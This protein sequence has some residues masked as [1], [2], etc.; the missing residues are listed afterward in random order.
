MNWLLD[1]SNLFI[2]SESLSV[3]N[4]MFDVRVIDV[5]LRLVFIP[6]AHPK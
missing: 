5:F 1:C 4:W 6:N 3:R 2:W